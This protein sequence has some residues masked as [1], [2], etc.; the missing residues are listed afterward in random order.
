MSGLYKRYIPPKPT[1][2]PQHTQVS[3]PIPR[4]VESKPA[5]ETP[6]HKRK[7]ERSQEEVAER[8]AKKLKKKGI[9]PATVQDFDTTSATIDDTV[10]NS[11]SETTKAQN[12]TA[13]KP[14]DAAKAREHA[15]A[16]ARGD[17]SHIVNMKKRHKLAKEYRK[18]HKGSDTSAQ[19]GAAAGASED[20]GEAEVA[21]G[22]PDLAEQK[23]ELTSTREENAVTEDSGLG[24]KDV[25]RKKRRKEKE[26]K[27]EK[28]EKDGVNED[29]GEI[30]V[31][32]AAVDDPETT[33]GSLDTAIPDSVREIASLQPKK[34]RHKLEAILASA[35]SGEEVIADANMEDDDH[36]RKHTR[37]LDNFQKASKRS[38]SLKSQPEQFQESLGNAQPVVHDLEMPDADGVDEDG[39]VDEESA[40]PEWL[41]KPTII[42]AESKSTFAALGLASDTVDR[43]SK[44]SFVDALPVQQA[45][46]PLLLP[47]GSAGARF[48]PGTD[49]ILPDVAVSAA[50]GSGKTIAYLLPM[51]E[52]LRRNATRGRL[53]ALVVVPTRE[54][55]VQVA[56]VADSLCKG[57]GLKVGMAT[58]TGKFKD[59]Q[60]RLIRRGSQYD[61]V[62]Y[63]RIA[64][65]GRREINPPE[66]DSEEFDSYLADLGKEDAKEEQR[67]RDTIHG[68]TQ[69]VATY[70]SAVDILVA[71][72]GRLLE[73]ISSTPGFNLVYLQWLIIDE[74]DKLL[75]N[76]YEGFL[77]S[78]NA[79]LARP[80]SIH[81][82]DVREQYLRSKGMWDDVRERRLRKVVLSATMTRDISKLTSLRLRRS[83]MIAV[84]GSEGI[85]AQARPGARGD[86][87]DDGFREN[88]SGFELPRTL[89]E[90]CV[91]VGDGSEKPLVV[92]ELLSAKIFKEDPNAP[93]QPVAL[94]TDGVVS[95]DEDDSSSSDSDDSSSI[96]SD[97]S[98]DV[99]SVASSADE[100]DEP[101][102]TNEG[103]T[104]M[105]AVLS[106]KLSQRHR[107]DSSQPQAPTVLIFTASNES[108]NRLSHLLKEIKPSWALRITTLVKLKPGKA[109][110][111]AKADEPAV[112]VSTDRAARGLDSFSNRPITHV[113]QYD[114]PRSLTGYIHRVGRTA[115]AGR[116]GDAWTLYT[117]SEAR[118]FV[119]EI[120]KAS[121]VKRAGAVERVKVF[122]SDDGLRERYQTVLGS[123]RE[124]VFGG[125][126]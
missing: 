41:A 17:F 116:D 106:Q 9:D 1:T 54:L 122:M 98:S 57:C 114:V 35:E 112:V 111:T 19:A 119:N 117:H 44:L 4:K 78:L 91:P 29:A 2:T 92:V 75:D 74:A 23:Y 73:H 93:L 65:L 55:V 104:D 56:A 94:K 15:L 16:E 79:E 83:T 31:A 77:D 46:L 95:D 84:R 86:G 109:R 7:R 3:T 21:A 68:I 80:R 50:T 51:I 82:Q 113:I 38:Q 14:N 42:S 89:I 33:L 76:Q 120:T 81:E 30:E 63:Q 53:G 27:E 100:P 45:L 90:Y 32:Q 12:A 8:K 126:T 72:P 40:L 105:D 28:E 22:E 64:E 125:K 59:E 61:P 43:L 87:R 13:A 52:A 107:K 6:D 20:A 34:R 101:K 58:G 121:N 24:S 25:K 85:D 60:D 48:L 47:P 118:W 71:T 96:S 123:M 88:A 49:S 69:H 10:D 5:I 67:M 115:R 102:D 108:A 66:A 18:T 36:L 26:E 11:V 110:I 97:S 103:T 70:D 39:F 99:S 124:E 37:V 62:E